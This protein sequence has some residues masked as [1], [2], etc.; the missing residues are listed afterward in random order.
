MIKKVLFLALCL[1]VLG[2]G[3]S[4]Y[5]S[6]ITDTSLGVT[7]TITFQSAGTDSYDVF[8]LVNTTTPSG[9]LTT[10]DFL[11]AVSLKLE[12]QD[13]DYTSTPTLLSVL[14]APAPG[15]SVTSDFAATQTGGLSGSGPGCNGSGNGFFCNE[16]TVMNGLRRTGVPVVGANDIYQ[17]EWLVNVTPGNELTNGSALSLKAGF[18]NIDGSNVGIT[19]MDGTLTPGGSTFGGPVPEPATF[20]LLG[21]GLVG[22]V[23]AI[24]RKVSN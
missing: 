14:M 16:T 22:I 6:T 2:P 4:L 11:N 19:S 9:S 8:L 3:H 18:V 1:L 24:R 21:T 17:F 5:A 7:Y 15:T 10:A 23:G 20:L 12:P 13:S